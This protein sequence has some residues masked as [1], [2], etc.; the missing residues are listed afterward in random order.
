MSPPALYQKKE[1]HLWERCVLVLAGLSALPK[2]SHYTSFVSSAWLTTWGWLSGIWL[3]PTCFHGNNLQQ[4]RA[5]VSLP[6]EPTVISCVLSHAHTDTRRSGQDRWHLWK[7]RQQ[8]TAAVSNSIFF[9]V[10]FVKF[11]YLVLDLS[12]A[13]GIER[14]MV[15]LYHINVCLDSSLF[16]YLSCIPAHKHT[17][18]VCQI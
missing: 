12:T 13:T 10:S 16:V 8:H 2:D 4:S 9:S 6:W 11:V 14:K 3:D 17:S 15:K 5:P 1:K 18:W 7:K